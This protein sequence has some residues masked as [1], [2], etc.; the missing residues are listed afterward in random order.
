MSSDERVEPLREAMTMV[1]YLSI[2]LLATLTALPAD[3]EGAEVAMK[4]AVSM[5]SVWLH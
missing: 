5:A 2:V 3:S 4:Q 1:L